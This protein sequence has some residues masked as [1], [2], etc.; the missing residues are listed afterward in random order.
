M[1][2]QNY[3][4]HSINAL[5]QSRLEQGDLDFTF[6]DGDV[7]FEWNN[8]CDEKRRWEVKGQLS[9]NTAD[10]NRDCLVNLLILPFEGGLGPESLQY[11]TKNLDSEALSTVNLWVALQNWEVRSFTDDE[12]RYTDDEERLSW[13]AE[14]SEYSDQNSSYRGELA[15]SSS[16][17]SGD[18]DDSEDLEDLEDLEYLVDI[19]T[20]G[21]E[22]INGKR[23]DEEN[24]RG[25]SEEESSEVEESEEEENEGEEEGSEEE[26]SEEEDIQ[27]VDFRDEYDEEDESEED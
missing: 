25:T 16:E 26:G 15:E 2:D 24:G 23:S 6:E 19:Q 5:L 20:A 9:E 13:V 4:W 14:D 27:G 3:S 8:L 12:S 21:E 7:L 10:F 1:D 17:S 18:L 22:S 11:V